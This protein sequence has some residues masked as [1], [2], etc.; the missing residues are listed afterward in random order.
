MSKLPLSEEVQRELEEE[1]QEKPEWVPLDWLFWR[2]S[3]GVLFFLGVVGICLF[4]FPW[5]DVSSPEIVTLSGAE[6]ARVL[7]W[8][9][10]C[11]VAWGTLIVT[12]VSRRSVAAMRGARVAALL[13]CAVPAITVFVLMLT[14]PSSR[15]IPVRF[16]YGWAFYATAAIALVGLPFGVLFGG[17]LKNLPMPSR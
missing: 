16:E 6:M 2:R 14:P 8:M 1:W 11:P 5:V 12:V 17:G 9:W 15:L 7:A 10:A 3:R 4:F 13:F